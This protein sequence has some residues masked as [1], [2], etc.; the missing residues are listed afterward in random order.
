MK[1]ISHFLCLEEEKEAK[2]STADPENA[3]EVEKATFAWGD[4]EPCL[5]DVSLRIKKG[6]LVAVVGDTGCGKSSFLLS[7]LGA[8]TRCE[9]AVRVSGSFALS[10]Q[11]AW[12]IN[13]SVRNNVLMGSAFDAT[14][15]ARVIA[16]AQMQSDLVLLGG[17]GAEIGD[18]GINV[19][20]GQKARISLA[21]CCYSDADIVLLDDPL[22]AVDARVGNRLFH[23]CIRKELRGRTRVLTTNAVQFLPF[24]DQ[25]VVIREKRVAFV[26]SYAEY[27]N[28]ASVASGVSDVSDVNSARDVSDV[29]EANRDKHT[30]DI[31][32]E[33][34]DKGVSNDTNANDNSPPPDTEEATIKTHLT[35]EEEKEH[36][37]ISFSVLGSYCRAFGT[38][39]PRR[40]SCGSPAGRATPAWRRRCPRKP[41]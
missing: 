16:A 39:R 17:E 3:I 29:S 19:S 30:S 25:V 22:A 8:L 14:R 38:L 26:G 12:I 13:D 33:K 31:S 28:Q 21:R 35:S 23:E 1:R 2:E 9:G 6:S 37:T 7:L 15:F 32:E 18:H 4:E 27:V 5:K 34:H 36:G 10:E 11:Q 20:G 24:C 40:R 41:A